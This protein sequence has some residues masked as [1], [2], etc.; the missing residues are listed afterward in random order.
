MFADGQS[1]YLLAATLRD[2]MLYF[3]TANPKPLL[4][5]SDSHLKTLREFA[6][7]ALAK[8]PLSEPADEQWAEKLRDS[9]ETIAGQM[10]IA[11]KALQATD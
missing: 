9:V 6:E 1:A 2:G 3:Q 4:H 8:H 10:Q 11:V 7:S 5:D